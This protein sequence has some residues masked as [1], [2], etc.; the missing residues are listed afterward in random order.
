MS[1]LIKKI[2]KPKGSDLEDPEDRYLRSEV[3]KGKMSEVSDQVSA[4]R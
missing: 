4:D 2:L 3:R 1:S